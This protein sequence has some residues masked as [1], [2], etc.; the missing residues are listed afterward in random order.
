MNSVR[1]FIFFFLISSI[2]SN[3]CLY[4]TFSTV[5]VN[6]ENSFEIGP[7]SES[8]YKYTLSSDKTK[9]I[10]LF[11]GTISF[12]SEVL[13]YKSKTDI[14]MIGKVYR[15]YVDRFL[16]N[17]NS[18]K[19]VDLSGFKD[20]IYIIIRDDKYQEIYK[21]NFIL[22]DTEKNITLTEGK[23]F[24]IKYFV[25]NTKYKFEFS[26]NKNLTFVYSTKIKLKKLLSIS[27]NDKII[28]PNSLDETDQIFNFKSEDSTIKKL[29][30]TVEDKGEAIEDKEFSLIVYENGESHFSEIKKGNLYTTNYLNLN[31]GEEKQQFFFYYYLGSYSKTNTI[32]FKLDP[33]NKISEYIN[34]QCGVYHSV[35]Q[36][37]ESERDIYF[38]FD[39]NKFPIEYDINSDDIKKIYFQDSDTSFAYRYLY[40]KV[41]IS[42]LNNYF[43]P[44]NFIISIG[45][46]LSEKNYLYINYYKT[47]TIRETIKPL[48]PFFVKLILDPKEKYILTS[49]FPEKTIFTK[50]DLLLKDENSNLKINQD[51]FTDPDEIIVLSNVAE[52][53]ITLINSESIT[54]TFYLEKYR[55]KELHII[56]NYR[57]YE[58]FDVVF[59]TN[60]CNSDSKKYLLGIYNKKIYS[61][62]N[63]TY[64]KYWTTNKGNF[65]VYYR[66]NIAIDKDSL[67]PSSDKYLQKKEFTIVLNFYYDF[68][69]F[70]CKEPGILSLRSPYKVFNETTH[71]ISQN[72]FLKFSISNKWEILQLTAPMKQQ[73]DFLYFGIFSKYGKKIKISPDNPLLFEDTSIEGDKVFLQ[74]VDLYRFESDQLAIKLMAE[75]TAQ[76][77]AV[78]VIKYNFTTYYQVRNAKKNKIRF[79]NFVKFLD[80]KR[81]R[82]IKV[83]IEKLK[84]VDICYG[85]VQLFTNNIN[86]LPMAYQ[87]KYDDIER[88]KIEG[89]ET[90]SLKNPFFN[91]KSGKKYTAFIFSIVSYNYY[92]YDVQITENNRRPI[93]D[94]DDDDDDEE[95][96]VLGIVL[97]VVGSGILIAIIV[98]VIY[99]KIKN[100]KPK[101]GEY[102]TYEN[103]ENENQNENQNN[104]NNNYNE[105]NQNS[106]NST[107]YNNNIDNNNNNTDN[108]N[109]DNNNI[110]NIN[111]NSKYNKIYRF[112]DE[113][114][115][116]KRLYKNLDED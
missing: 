73:T 80:N 109:L 116:D 2:Y 47:Q 83:K 103:D 108:N 90:F 19:E 94:D 99:Y 85:I 14:S 44:K 3:L 7:N 5:S 17:E 77:E 60:E 16:I 38:K 102:T 18:F 72:A 63:R 8:C 37:V 24:T 13:L 98:I 56:E 42:K 84:N 12:T 87:F 61:K 62:Y 21:N 32:N 89:K 111:K 27:Y 6:K 104:D 106:I 49:P 26:S 74:R 105:T 40:F 30:V 76:I 68:F 93:D 46:D 91:N 9:I 29:Y 81:I 86:Y 1:I 15:N 34:I 67:F 52:L 31:R 35:K 70:Y 10:L 58:P 33:I 95:S 64:T 43:S 75:D 54:A 82:E 23:P 55:E 101:E 45:N 107:D 39:Q 28:L 71:L 115:E 48:I 50:G 51:R 78:E 22:Y 41:E 113:E 97:A 25:R 79:N 114:D 88:K 92:E 96:H 4:S 20:E 112:D 36:I 11:P 59:D 57:N 69:T 65:N 53:T 110:N 100:S 66:N